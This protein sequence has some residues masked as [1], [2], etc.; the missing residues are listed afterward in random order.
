MRSSRASIRSIRLLT[1]AIANSKLAIATSV[2][3]SLSSTLVILTFNS[4][5]FL[6]DTIEFRVEA[7]Q[8]LVNENLERSAIRCSYKIPGSINQ[9]LRLARPTQTRETITR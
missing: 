5:Y 2:L 6:D 4:P 9:Y 1:P 7:P 8:M 3:V